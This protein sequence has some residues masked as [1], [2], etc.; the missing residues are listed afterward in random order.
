[1][2]TTDAH[3]SFAALAESAQQFADAV[4]E[5]AQFDY[6]GCASAARRL[7]ETAHARL[8]AQLAAVADQATYEATRVET[9]PVVAARL[10]VTRSAV[11]AAVTRHRK[12]TA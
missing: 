4:A 2:T 1:M 5:L 11:E 12:R 8:S 9:Q 3:L 6:V 7:A 10:G